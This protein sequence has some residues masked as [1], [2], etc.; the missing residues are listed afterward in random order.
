[1]FDIRV[2]ED[3]LVHLIGRLDAA[4]AE[5]AHRALEML[6]RSTTFDCGQL[7]YISRLY[8]NR[9]AAACYVDFRGFENACIVG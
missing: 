4:E 1:M 6:H 8:P 3:G 9:I 7:E 2:G 5:N